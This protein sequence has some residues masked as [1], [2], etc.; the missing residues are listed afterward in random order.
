MTI[1]ALQKRLSSPLCLPYRRYRYRRPLPGSRLYASAKR[2]HRRILEQIKSYPD[3]PA[4]VVEAL[5]H[6]INFNENIEKKEVMKM[7]KWKCTVCGYIHDG[8]TPPEICPVCKHPQAY[9][10]VR[11]ENY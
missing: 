6:N 10:E 9:F 8:D 7:A 5:L 2:Q 4:D 1:K 11:K 3:I